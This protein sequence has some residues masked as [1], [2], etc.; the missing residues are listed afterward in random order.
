MGGKYAYRVPWSLTD[1]QVVALTLYGEASGEEY[2]TQM[3]IGN[4]ITN[5]W[6]LKKRNRAFRPAQTISD[7]CLWPAQFTC[8]SDNNWDRIARAVDLNLSP[9]E[10]RVLKQCNLIAEGVVRGIWINRLGKGDTYH[11][12]PKGH[13]KTPSWATDERFIVKIGKTSVYCL[14]P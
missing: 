3:L 11:H 10:G 6:E 5:R 4:I 13:P 1:T 9:Y 8:W 7:I 2:D 12:Y 14:Y